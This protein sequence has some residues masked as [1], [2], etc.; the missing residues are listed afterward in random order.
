MVRVATEK[1]NGTF[2]CV[3]LIDTILAKDLL[4]DGAI[5]WGIRRL[6]K[7]RLLDERPDDNVERTRQVDRFAAQLR[8]MPVAVETQAAN[9]QHY[10][11]PATF[12]KLCLGPRLK[13][14]SCFYTTGTETI[15]QAEE[16]MLALTCKRAELADGMEILELGC[17]WGSLTL[18]MAEHYPNARITA[19][20]NSASQ[21]AHIEGECAQRGFRNVR[22]ITQDMNLFAAEA[23]RFDRVVSVEMFEHMKNWAEL[24]RRIGSWLKPGGKLFFHVFTHRD[25]A[26]HFEPKDE[27]DWMSR[28]FFTGGIMP[29]NDLA[30]RF[31]D[32]LKL[33]THWEV[34]GRH[35]GQTAEHWLQNTDAHRD[36]VLRIFAETY[37]PAHARKW[38]AYWRVFF[39]ACAELW[40]FRGGAEWMV[41]HY[42]FAK[43]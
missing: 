13:Y 34:E 8:S 9:E 33:E 23:S 37:G 6:L 11:V 41:C 32:D 14:S 3:P 5:R 16:T 24:M 10:E 18:W 39:M 43:K 35:Y 36:E 17:G 31:Q 2:L 29:S 12:Y 30:M 42:R 20:S 1:E 15:A 21:R 25:I 28:H 26:Y 22:I 19:V 40:N 38:L 27:S 4:P 7:Q